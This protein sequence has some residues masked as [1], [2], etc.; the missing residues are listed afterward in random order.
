M[1]ENRTKAQPK[2]TKT[3][4]KASVE[5]LERERAKLHDFRADLETGETLA[6]TSVRSSLLGRPD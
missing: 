1:N 5:T 2:Q 6:D 4:A 3:T